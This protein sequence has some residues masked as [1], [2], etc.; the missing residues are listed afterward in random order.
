MENKNNIKINDKVYFIDDYKIIRGKV[1]GINHE[2]STHELGVCWKIQPEKQYI[3]KEYYTVYAT[4][5]EALKTLFVDV[6]DQIR[7][8]NNRI[9][10]FKKL[11]FETFEEFVG[12]ECLITK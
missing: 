10:Y 9:E 12:N 8:L 7:D 5:K 6:T 2:K 4:K 3:Y 1:V 11:Q